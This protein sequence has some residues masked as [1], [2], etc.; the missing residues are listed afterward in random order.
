VDDTL[1]K[2][3]VTI[4]C[5][6]FKIKIVCFTLGWSVIIIL[7]TYLESCWLKRYMDILPAIVIPSIRNYFSHINFIEDLI[8]II[9]LGLVHIFMQT[10]IFTFI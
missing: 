6:K 5:Q 8:F 3:G 2:L 4:N 10:N 7:L 9:I 1:E